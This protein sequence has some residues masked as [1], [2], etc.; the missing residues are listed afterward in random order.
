MRDI[1]DA[2]PE[3]LS[4]MMNLDSPPDQ[5][6]HP[7]DLAAM[8]RHQMA[9]TVQFDLG[10]LDRNPAMQLSN[11]SESQ[12]LLLKSFGDLFFHPHPP[13]ELLQLTKQY[14]K[15]CR[16]HPDSPLP[17]EIA[18]L[19]YFMAIT[20]ALVRCGERIT[21]LDDESLRKGIEWAIEQ[22][23]VDEKTRA[24]L[25]EGLALVGGQR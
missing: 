13:I 14:A 25:R 9:A 7:D 12:G 24:L 2:N 22:A 21:Q 1:R 19:L 20:T 4:K 6:W 17:H 23:W 5:P 16:N 11:L 3:V 18:T 10:A 8:L 15:A